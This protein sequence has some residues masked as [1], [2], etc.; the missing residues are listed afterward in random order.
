MTATFLIDPWRGDGK[1]HVEEYIRSLGIPASIFRPGFYMS[2]LPGMSLRDMG[3]GSWALSLPTPDDSPIPLFDAE[4]DTGKFVKA[5]FHNKDKVLG[6]RVYGAT[7]CYTP[8]QILDE[9]KELFPNTGK[10]TAYWQLSAGEFKGLMASPGTSEML[11]EQVLQNM[12][13]IPELRYYYHENVELSL[14]VSNAVT[15]IRPIL[16]ADLDLQLLT[17]KP[18]TWKEY[19]KKDPAFASLD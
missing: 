17:E 16:F 12:R 13:L 15:N 18:T 1:L 14:G 10:E 5:M 19:A 2:H 4:G 6:Q 7:A 3:D 8:V 11:Q 9:F